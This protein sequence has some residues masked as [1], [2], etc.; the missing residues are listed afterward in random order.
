MTDPR[1]RIRA[2]LADREA[3]MLSAIERLVLVN[4]HT[5]NRAGGTLTGEMLAAEL[6][7]VEGISIRPL[8]STRFAPHLVITTLAAEASAEGC[9]AII[10]HLDTVFPPGTFEGFR[11]EGTLARGP[12]VLDMKGGLVVAFEALRALAAA[13]V[14]AQAKIRFVI[15][16]DEEVGSPESQPI[17]RRE[18]AG[19]ACALVLE[20]G[21]AGD[22]V[23]TSRK[24]TGSATAV[25]TGKAAHAGNA[26]DKGANAIWALARFVDRAQALTDY[27]RGVTV[28]AGKFTGGQG[29]NTVPDRAECLL[30]FRFERIA[31][32]EA[33]FAAL[34][35]AGDEAAR[36]V[37]GTSIVVEGGPARMPLERTEANVALYREYAACARA[38]GLGDGEAPLLGGGSDASTTAAMGI[39]SIDGLGPRG[40]GFHTTDE[41]IEV[42]SLVPKAEAMAAFLL[43]RATS[44]SPSGGA[45]H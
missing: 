45:T 20:A 28:N 19:A 4:S 17:L 23:I 32:A 41:L 21:R 7:F 8:P 9:V 13:S 10:G 31:D 25:A 35:A 29:K 40:S 24:G 43:G 44:P 39:P 33:T 14:L 16:S 15:V 6:A 18:L 42:A 12:G 38:A 34:R 1:S 3:P 26:H 22:K 5:D 27:A 11:H 36:S 30:D 2:Y 37:P